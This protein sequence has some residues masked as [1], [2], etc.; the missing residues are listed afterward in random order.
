M[1]FSLAAVNNQVIGWEHSLGTSQDGIF[2]CVIRVILW[3]DL[4]NSWDW[5]SMRVDDVTNKFSVVLVD[6]NDIDVIALQESL[7]AIFKF[8]DWSILKKYVQSFLCV[9]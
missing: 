9:F 8:A 2:S 1:Y 7:E 4:E 5:G 6:Q 3:R